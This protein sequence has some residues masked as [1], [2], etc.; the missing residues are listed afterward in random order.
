MSTIN[1]SLG[2]LHVD[3]KTYGNHLIPTAV[4]TSSAT[5]VGTEIDT[6]GF[7]YI[8]YYVYANAIGAGSA[9]VTA[10]DSAASGS[11]FAAASGATGQALVASACIIIPVSLDGKNRY[12][13]ISITGTGVTTTYG[14][15]AFLSNSAVGTVPITQPT[16][17]TVIAA[18]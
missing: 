12:H 3:F 10:H 8:T 2:T 15:M 13:K 6:I 5:T 17:T 4:T 16:G 9:A 7:R 18:I 1:S 14:A 11:G